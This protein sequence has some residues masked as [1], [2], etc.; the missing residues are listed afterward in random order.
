[1]WQVKMIRDSVKAAIPFQ[2]TLRRWKRRLSPYRP[3][4]GNSRMALAQGLDQIRLLRAAGADLG[5]TL[6]EIGSGWLPIIPLLFRIA[7]ARGTTLTDIEPLMDEHTIASARH[8]IAE[9]RA[10]VARALE[11]PVET[12]DRRLAAPFEPD[13]RVPWRP[14]D[15]AD[16]SADLVVSRTVLEHIAPPLLATLMRELHRIVRP[17]GLMCHI[18]DNSDH[19]EHRDKTISRVNFLRFE[20]GPLWRLACFNPQNYQNRL[21][22][23][24]YLELFRRTGWDVVIAEGEPDPRCL[25]DLRSMPLARPF[26]GRSFRDLAILTSTFVLRRAPAAP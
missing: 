19:W 14:R 20:D 13:Y 25:E 4:A 2:Q 7:G 12:V 10:A 9:E 11:L 22:H 8:F 18:V 23:S 5:G 24:D 17:G 3:D 1:M 6:L 26:R 15:S 16:G 21:R